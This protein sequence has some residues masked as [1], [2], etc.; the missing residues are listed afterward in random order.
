MESDILN[1][2]KNG[3]SFLKLDD[4]FFTVIINKCTINN[5]VDIKKIYNAINEMIRNEIKHNI[6][7][8]IN[9]LEQKGNCYNQEEAKECLNNFTSFLKEYDIKI[10][11]DL[12]MQLMTSSSLFSHIIEMIV[13][14]NETYQNNI[15]DLNEYSI[16]FIDIYYENNLKEIYDDNKD[17][18]DQESS[19]YITDA[20]QQYI[21]EI[22]KIPLLT[23]EDE[24]ELTTIY[25]KTKSKKIRNKIIESNLRLVVS[26]A[27]QIYRKNRKIPFGELISIGN[28]G[29]FKALEDYDPDIARFSTYATGKIKQ[30]MYREIQNT[31]SIIRIPVGVQEDIITYNRNKKLLTNKLGRTPTIKEIAD[32]L[33]I[34]MKD[35]AIYESDISD[36]VSLN[37]RVKEDKNTELIEFVCST[38]NESPEHIV[39]SKDYVKHLR[40]S[41]LKL[42]KSELY[43]LLLRSGLYDGIKYNLSETSEKLYD[44]KI[45]NKKLS[46]ERIRQ[47]ESIAIEKAKKIID[48]EMKNIDSINDNKIHNEILKIET[49]LQNTDESIIEQILEKLPV[50]H[51]TVLKNCFGENLLK[52]TLQ[53]STIENQNIIIKIVWPK[54][55]SI[56][57]NITT[58][59]DDSLANTE[60]LLNNLYQMYNEESIDKIDKAID[61][62]TPTERLELYKYYDMY[63]GNFIYKENLTQ[64]QIKSIISIIQKIE[65][66]LPIDMRK[67]KKY[68]KKNQ[69]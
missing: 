16:Q 50:Y 26:I 40:Q 38:E 9:F 20:I 2:L 69:N 3:F 61:N 46:H 29:L 30:K 34:S 49:F 8:L 67:H 15:R 32:Y 39:V 42:T 68:T 59:K 66:S 62:L 28:E 60:Y 48:D 65:D 56:F 11:N 64:E 5:E 17:I 43:V 45:K 53:L 57:N 33:K 14:D 44:L 31:K 4:Q 21:N 52:P 55:I 58:K 27:K 25:R 13:L 19:Y 37:E 24:Y 12:Y 41:F 7:Y 23:K 35:I 18:Q 36:V 47:I 10:T 6:S 51:I 63:T 54:V 1:S 22:N